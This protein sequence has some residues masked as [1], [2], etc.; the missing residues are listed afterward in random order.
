MTPRG[1]NSK[2]I[3]VSQ[4]QNRVVR[5]I[6]ERKNEHGQSEHAPNWEKKLKEPRTHLAPD[7]T[8]KITHDL[9]PK[10]L[11][12]IFQKTPSS[13]YYNRQGCITNLSAWQCLH[14]R[15]NT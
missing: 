4:L 1:K 6:T 13:E 11:I 3:S 8:Y 5:V 9:A 10:Q 14:Q 12:V 7:L 2:Q 15:L